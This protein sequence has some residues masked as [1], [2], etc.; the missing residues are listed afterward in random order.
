[1]VSAYTLS[2]CVLFVPVF[3]AAV[4]K[5]RR[6][7]PVMTVFYVGMVSFI[8]FSFVFKLDYSEVK[9]LIVSVL[10]FTLMCVVCKFSRAK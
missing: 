8:L 9:S 3:V 6:L 4:S 7:F 1:M 10:V 2:V 5:A